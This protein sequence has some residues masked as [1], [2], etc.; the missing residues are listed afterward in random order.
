LDTVFTIYCII[1]TGAKSTLERKTSSNIKRGLDNK[2][3]I[4]Y[5]RRMILR[6]HAASL[7]DLVSFSVRP[8]F[9]FW[10]WAV[11]AAR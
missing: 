3:G 9:R 10:S 11:P 1:Y 8:G 6:G 5:Q 4:W 7:P 2:G